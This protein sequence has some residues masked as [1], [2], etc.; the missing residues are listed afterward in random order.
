[1]P[2]SA[3]SFI[4]REIELFG[5]DSLSATRVTDNS[6]CSVAKQERM[7]VAFESDDMA[8]VPYFA[9]QLHYS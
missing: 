9:T 6:V 8:A 4:R 3:I 7:L 5:N 1:M 2:S